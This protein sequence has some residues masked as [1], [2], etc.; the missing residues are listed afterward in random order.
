MRPSHPH[1]MR[2]ATWTAVEFFARAA[3]AVQAADASPSPLQGEAPLAVCRWSARRR[4]KTYTRRNKNYLAILSRSQN[5][6]SVPL[7]MAL[8][9]GMKRVPG[10]NGDGNAQRPG[11]F[12]LEL[13]EAEHV[14][15]LF[16]RVVVDEEI[17]V[18]VG[19]VG[20]ARA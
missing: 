13:H 5:P 19:P 3:I 12:L 15:Y 14:R 20:V 6:N 16:D 11:N 4:V 17:E 2:P 1:P 18:A 10:R 7:D 9:Q 8:L